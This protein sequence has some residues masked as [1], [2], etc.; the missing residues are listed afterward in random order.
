MPWI[1]WPQEAQSI[2]QPKD[3]CSPTHVQLASVFSPEQIA[4]LREYGHNE[5]VNNPA[6]AKTNG[7][8][9]VLPKF[10][11]DIYTRL[12]E[13][14]TQANEEHFKFELWGIIRVLYAEYPVN[15]FIESHIDE[16][17]LTKLAFSVQLSAGDE[18]DGGDLNLHL[19][20]SISLKPEIGSRELGS[21][22]LHQ[23]LVLHSM[24]PVTRGTRRGLV[25]W[26][27]GPRIK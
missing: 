18:Y 20:T 2:Q 17:N 26:V 22:V 15:A 8:M 24:S 13:V 25:A 5:M 3:H 9:R 14:I 10:R 27:A 16:T 6:M 19:G 7:C 11:D 21:G 4:Y 23:A 1:K 12:W